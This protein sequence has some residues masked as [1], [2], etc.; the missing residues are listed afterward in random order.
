VTQMLCA[1][2]RKK[3]MPQ[4]PSR[5]FKPEEYGLQLKA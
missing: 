3:I 4:E 5:I 2:C 1:E